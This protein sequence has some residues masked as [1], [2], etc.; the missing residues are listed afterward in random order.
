MK[1][2]H[3]NENKLA[4]DNLINKSIDLIYELANENKARPIFYPMSNTVVRA[5]KSLKAFEKEKP[6]VSDAD[7]GVDFKILKLN[8]QM[9]PHDLTNGLNNLDKSSISILLEQKLNQQ[10][11]FLLS[12]KDRID[13][14]SSKVF[15][16]GDLNAGKSTFCNALL[17]RK[18]LPED[19]QP[20]TS[21]FCEIIDASKDNNSVEEVHAVPHLSTYNI[22]DETTYQIF[23]LD[24]LEHL[25]YE[26]EKFSFLKVYL[27]DVR[28]KEQSLLRNGVIDIRLIDAPGLNM[29]SYQTTQVFSRQEEIDL[30]VFVV[31]SENHF[32][33]SGKEFISSAAGEK[34]YLFIVANK[35][36]NIRDKERC[37]QK[38]LEQV[39]NLSPDSYKDAQS[40]VHFVSASDAF[41]APEGGGDGDGDG[42]DNDDGFSNPDFDQLEASLRNFVLEKRAISKLL[43][44][45]NFLIN[46][47]KDIRILSEVNQAQYI[48]EKEQK[49]HDLKDIIEPKYDGILNQSIVINDT[50]LKLM[51]KSSSSIYQFTKDELND[52]IDNLG[53][54]QIVPYQGIQFAYAYAQETQRRMID[55]II[56]AVNKCEEHSKMQTSARVE[57]IIKYGQET[58]GDEFLNDKKFQPE[59]MFTRRRDLIKKNLIQP[60]ELGDFFDPSIESCLSWIGLPND[61]VSRGVGFLSDY[62]PTSIITKL[63]LTAITLREQ[64]PAQLT[65]HTLYSSSKIL[66]VG[67]ILRK[68][69]SFSHVLT[70]QMMKRVAGPVLLGFLGFSV[71]YLINDIPN[72]FPRKQA[73]KMKGQIQDLEYVHNN[74]DRISKECRKVLNY[75]LRQVMNNFQTS[76]DKRGQEKITLEEQI[77]NSELSLNYF[78][79]LIE[80]ID[81]EFKLIANVNLENVNTVD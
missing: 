32:T 46:I 16:T 6:K 81:Y 51:E 8:L 68:L 19:Q 5:D 74:A 63:P 34:Q 56:S 11:K 26:Q 79:D 35:F 60:I 41:N 28:P 77:K 53:D 78:N 7:D 14:T 61:L 37:K 70:P 65:L 36:D 43:P 29:D 10:V 13:D 2:L 75:P 33:L 31:N 62:N 18:V 17:R 50:I 15:V 73:R 72:A 45:K 3:Y 54:S 39:K 71:Y 20:C 59:L 69:Y 1:Q 76:I 58:L 9:S 57:E 4:L 64:L 49:L 24:D 12:L 38:I 55:S 40:F 48:K 30:I 27:N 44:A 80:K 47:L 25:V 21:V 66:T 42:P 23:T 52:S 67:T 22:K